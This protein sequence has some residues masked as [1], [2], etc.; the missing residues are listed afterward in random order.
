MQA[1]GW[2]KASSAVQKN[3]A[4][5]YI[6]PGL[7]ISAVFE[8]IS[9]ES[10]EVRAQPGALIHCFASGLITTGWQGLVAQ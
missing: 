3:G 2:Q 4:V 7:E 6:E 8:A 10:L 9:R 1:G 5:F